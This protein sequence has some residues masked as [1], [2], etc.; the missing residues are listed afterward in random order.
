[1]EILFLGTGSAEGIPRIGC[2]CAHCQRARAEG[3]KLRRERSAILVKLPDYNLLVDTPPRV[4]RLLDAHGIT[5]L[6][7]IYLTHAH[8]DHSGGLNEFRY[9]PGRLDLIATP[10]VYRSV[11]QREWGER[12]P[13]I[14]F[15]LPCLPGAT[16]HFGAFHLVPFQVVH[17]V[18]TYG[19]ALFEGG[20]KVVLTSDTGVRFSRYARLL[21]EGADVLITNTP[22]FRSD[23]EDHLDV[24]RALR[25]K[26]AL[27]VKRLILTHINHDNKPHDELAAHVSTHRGVE[28]AYDGFA[29]EV[30][31]GAEAP[32]P[33]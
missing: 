1:M 14:A 10:D 27:R 29:L 4:R 16:L 13:E 8:Y 22:F 32:A 31:A 18:P 26:E 17:T 7:G 9:W 11:R 25:L 15:H 23:R 5:Q 24:E 33:V 19:L 28:V 6:D 21:I 3:G 2:T 30:P 12:L 20:H